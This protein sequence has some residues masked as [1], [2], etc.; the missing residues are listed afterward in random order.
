M[1]ISKSDKKELHAPT[2]K[3][4]YSIEPAEREDRWHAILGLGW[5][6]EY[7]LYR[8]MW[9]ESPQKL[10]VGDY[11]LLVDLE[12]STVCNLQCPMCYTITPEFRRHVNAEFMAVTLFRKVIDEISRKVPAVRLSLRGEP[13]LHPHFIDCVNYA[14]QA[15]VHEVSTLT[16]GSKLSRE[17]FIK[18]V[19]SGLDWITLSIDGMDSTYESIRKPIKYN[20]MLRTLRMMKEVKR[21]L[22][23][24][25]PVVKIQTVWPAIR[26]NAEL[27]Y[28]SLSPYADLIAINPLIDYLNKDDEI[29][30][31]EDFIC[32]QH[33]Q[34]LIVCAD[35][36]VLACSN[37]EEGRNV[38]GDVHEQTIAEIW[39]GSKLN[40]V[41]KMLCQKGGFKEFEICRR[42]YLPRKTVNNERAYIN[43]REIIIKNYINRPQTIGR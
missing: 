39:H 17:Y 34:R 4:N 42:C 31:E 2:N 18:I 37:D 38:V 12:L 26:D 8:N 10:Y 16:N 24:K 20:D 1:Y 25:K 19:E 28:N 30:Y 27:Y 41:R 33:Y 43:G 6:N 5:E 40:K 22:N 13:T 32:P 35:G 9:K 7:R 14:K 36:K 3:G 15:G 23:R 29:V 11:P 21:K